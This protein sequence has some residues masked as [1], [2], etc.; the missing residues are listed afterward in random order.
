MVITDIITE[1]GA[2][3]RNNRQNMNS[4]LRL[5]Y[6]QTD[7]TKF[8][9]PI[10][11]DGTRWEAAKFTFGQMLQPFQKAVTVAGSATAKPVKWDL[12]HLKMDVKESPDDLEASWLGFLASENV[13]RTEWPF[14]RWM[15]E[16]AMQ[17][18]ARDYELNEIYKGVYSAPTA[19]TPGAPGTA[20]NGIGKIIAD[21]ITATAITPITL[22]AISTTPV[23]FLEQVET[24][25]RSIIG[26]NED[27]GNVPMNV[28]MSPTLAMRYK[29]GYREKYGNQ[30]DFTGVGAKVID[31]NLTVVPLSS[32]SG[33]SRIW[34]SPKEN[35][36][37]L[38][39]RTAREGQVDIQPKDREVQI[40]A[41][42]WRGVGFGLLEAVFCNELA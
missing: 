35:I 31:T 28:H 23:T 42:H 36:L 17:K 37:D 27:Y 24:F 29:T 2:Y 6:A 33:R 5:Q 22:G 26:I 12:Y 4:L 3:Y 11:V 38:R 1:Y 39:F 13:K 21:A 34:A 18:A 32:M 16:Q 7:T 8:M 20:M 9:T 14:V 15:M 30:S 41:D 40:L 25:A 19:N 10:M